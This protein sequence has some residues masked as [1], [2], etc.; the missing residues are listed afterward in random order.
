[1]RGED[2]AQFETTVS[3]FMECAGE[4]RQR[5]VRAREDMKE[6]S[7]RKIE[8]LESQVRDMEQELTDRKRQPTR[9]NLQAKTSLQRSASW[10]ASTLSLLP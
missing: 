9:R 6:E 7:G 3:Q 10:H 4:C 8:A 2:A 1:M 5:K